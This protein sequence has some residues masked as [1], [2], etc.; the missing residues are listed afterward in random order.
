MILSLE[1]VEALRWLPYLSATGVVVTSSSPFRNIVDYPELPDVLEAL[2]GLPRSVVV[3]ADP[4]ARE[5]GSGHA[6]NVVMLGA[7]SPLLPFP[8]EALV[9]CVADF[10]AAKGE[11]VVEL[12]LR[13]FALGKAAGAAAHR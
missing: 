3:D 8:E 13:A 1:P 10:F 9:G 11:K 5:A 2:A 6:N 12:N 4:L 7:A